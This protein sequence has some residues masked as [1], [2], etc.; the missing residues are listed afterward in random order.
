MKTPSTLFA[1][2]AAD[3]AEK[4]PPVPGSSFLSAP[5]AREIS[6]NAANMASV[7]LPN[8]VGVRSA[9]R[10]ARSHLSTSACCPHVGWPTDTLAAFG[11]LRPSLKVLGSWGGKQPKSSKVLMLQ[12]L[13][14]S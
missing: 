1:L 8:V 2:P 12:R 7:R 3:C 6:S 14:G 11:H 13:S 5:D 10:L 9:D 4:G